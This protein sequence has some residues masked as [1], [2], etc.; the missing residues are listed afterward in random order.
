MSMFHDQQRVLQDRFDSRRLADG[1]EATNVHDTLNPLDTGFIGM[2]DFFFLAT[3]DAQGKPSCSFK[4]GVMGF[5][6]IVD[7]KT[8]AFPCYDGNGM[9]LSMGNV[10]KT[11]QVG[12]LFID[13]QK[14]N[15]L[16]ISGT[17]SIMDNDPLLAD[18]PEA[19]FMVRVAVSEIFL[20]CP[21]YIPKM[22]RVASSQFI[23][24]KGKATPFPSWKTIDFVRDTLPTKD[25][26]IASGKPAITIE[27]YINEIANS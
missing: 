11:A 7:E 27:D 4:A 9:F 19:L 26:A 24:V 23:P 8:L 13:F 14:P 6:K 1:I 25:R 22:S 5:V 10:L 21:R 12:L 18:Y 3:T 17:A 16:R 15:R 20:N 2:Q